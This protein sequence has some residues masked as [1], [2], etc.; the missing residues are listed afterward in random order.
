MNNK[1]IKGWQNIDK[2]LAEYTCKQIGSKLLKPPSY[3]DQISAKH[4]CLPRACGIRGQ[5][6]PFHVA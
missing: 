6:F 3:A 5:R 1:R 4:K 2:L